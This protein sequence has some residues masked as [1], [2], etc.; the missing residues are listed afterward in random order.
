MTGAE[1]CLA[2]ALFYE[3]GICSTG[4]M[5]SVA[6]VILTSVESPRY[7]DSI[8]GVIEEKGRFSFVKELDS[9]QLTN[10]ADQPYKKNWNKAKMVAKAYVEPGID[11]RRALCF[12][13]KDSLP[14]WAMLR[15][16]L[17]DREGYYHFFYTEC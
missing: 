4:E 14:D 15:H 11:Y 3:C 1:L 17:P 12:H 16:R 8:C 10:P 2:I 6:G 9:G 5:E 7:A 13:T